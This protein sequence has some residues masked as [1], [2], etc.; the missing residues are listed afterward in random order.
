MVDTTPTPAPSRPAVPTD[1]RMRVG[2]DQFKF[3][4]SALVFHEGRLLTTAYQDA[5]YCYL[6]GG[7][8]QIGEAAET[9]MHRE[10]VEELGR[11][12]PVG[13]P[14]LIA[15]SLYDHAGDAALRHELTF[16]FR[17]DIPPGL[18]PDDLTA[19]PEE[20]HEFRWIPLDRLAESTF[21]PSELI[22][23]LPELATPGRPVG[24][25]LVDLRRAP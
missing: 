23:I 4:V 3:R 9:A 13:D 24:H 21:R 25:L 10:L 22:G 1:V 15:E 17:L 8:V 19:Q 11:D 12:L 14:V 5:D 20:G 7:K 18:G 2:E 16:Y 6:P